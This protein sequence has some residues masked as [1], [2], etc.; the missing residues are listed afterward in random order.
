[1]RKAHL[2]AIVL[3]CGCAHQQQTNK[4][5]AFRRL[6]VPL[7]GGWYKCTACGNRKTNTTM[8]KVK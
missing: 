8:R 3:P 1:M 4:Y 6:H 5:G 7:A 2:N